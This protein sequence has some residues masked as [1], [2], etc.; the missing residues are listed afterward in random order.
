MPEFDI[1]SSL[2]LPF[3]YTFRRLTS[4]DEQSIQHFLETCEDFALLEGGISPQP[5]DGARFLQDNPPGKTL[6]DKFAFTIEKDKRIIALLDLVRGYPEEN[7]WWIG[8][9]LMDP[10]FRG[11]GIGR[12][13]VQNLCDSIQ[14]KG[15]KE[16]RLGVLEEN[17]PGIRFWSKAGFS[18]LEIKPGREFGK[19]IHTVIVMQKFL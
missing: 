9:F 1:D 14:Q 6:E 18:V 16:I 12:L 11:R 3:N 19:K 4:L 13:V 5:G 8:L 15:A 17:Q 10:E 2:L 7:I